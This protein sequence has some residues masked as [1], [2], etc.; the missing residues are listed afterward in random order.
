MKRKRHYVA[1][2]NINAWYLDSGAT[3]HMSPRRT[4]FTN[5][6]KIN[7]E[8]PI[9]IGNGQVIYAIGVGDIDVLA[10]NGKQWNEMYLQNVLY[11]PELYA[12]LFSQGKV[13]DKGSKFSSDK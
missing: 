13:L 8:H 9:R 3:E 6:K 7:G 2:D 11:V 4:W 1:C 5:Y 10:Y 12:N